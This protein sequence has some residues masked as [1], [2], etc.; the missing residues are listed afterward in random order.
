VDTPGLPNAGSTREKGNRNPYRAYFLGEE[1][2]GNA[3]EG[4]RHLADKMPDQDGLPAVPARKRDAGM[5]CGRIVFLS[6][7]VHKR[8]H[9]KKIQ[10]VRCAVIFF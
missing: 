10:T 5:A 8:F 7:I 9:L 6:E 2:E 4:V 3:K 1:E